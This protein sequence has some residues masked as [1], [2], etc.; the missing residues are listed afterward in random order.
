MGGNVPSNGLLK[1]RVAV[2]T[3]GAQ[4]IGS[5]IATRF[6]EQGAQVAIGDV[7]VDAGTSVVDRL[8]TSG[9]EAIFSEMD[10][11]EEAAVHRMLDRCLDAFGRV[12]ILVNNAGINVSGEVV[13]L[14]R[15]AWERALSVNLTGSFLCSQVFCRHMI[16]QGEGGSVIFISSQAG[17]RGEANAAAY[18]A[19]KFGVLGLMESLALEMAPYGI[20]ANAVC[21][22]NVDTP[23]I[24]WLF[25]DMARRKGAS[26]EETR[27]HFADLNPLGR[28][29]MPTEI[30]D[31]CV[32]LA[33]P[34]ASYVT[35]E[36]INV[37]GG[38]LSG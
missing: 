25:E 24:R 18:C 33:S 22:G 4:G 11:T 28:L 16:E 17:K 5:G 12:D 6:A 2:V 10:V 9:F 15:D 21:P 14:S 36:S 27:K 38:E 19:S 35:G 37:D 26:V 13:E 7:Q 23:M 20:R 29:A 30:A 32:F 8:S 34:M 1:D 3:G 31:V